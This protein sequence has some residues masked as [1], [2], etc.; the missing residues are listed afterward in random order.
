MASV[1]LCHSDILGCCWK[2]QW[3]NQWIGLRENLHRKPWFLHVFTIKYRGLV[4][5]FFPS[6]NS[7]VE[8][9]GSDLANHKFWK[10]LRGKHILA[11][12]QRQWCQ[13]KETGDVAP[14]SPWFSSMVASE[15]FWLVVSKIF[16]WWSG[17]FLDGLEPL[18][19]EVY[20]TPF[21]A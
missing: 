2:P 3:L 1:P 18:S 19:S 16:L 10:I 13:A 4:Y 15:V 11:Q 17:C 12:T 8:E 14:F 5:F 9:S 21:M 20:C 6:S 7:M